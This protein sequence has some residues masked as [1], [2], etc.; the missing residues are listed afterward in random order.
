MRNFVQGVLVCLKIVKH[1][2]V[3]QFNIFQ[4]KRCVDLNRIELNPTKSSGIEPISVEQNRDESS[5][6]DS[7]RPEL[8]FELNRVDLALIH[9]ESRTFQFVPPN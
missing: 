9:A 7:I 4:G 2:Q 6:M 5:P 3:C 8:R 1:Y